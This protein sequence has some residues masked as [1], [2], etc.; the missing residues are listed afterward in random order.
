MA[1]KPLA[2]KPIIKK[3]ETATIPDKKDEIPDRPELIIDLGNALVKIILSYV[4]TKGVLRYVERSFPHA[5]AIV[6]PRQYEEGLSRAGNHGIAYN[7]VQIESNRYVI[8]ESAEQFN[9]EKRQ[10]RAKYAEDYYVPFVLSVVSQEFAECPELLRNGIDVMASHAPQDVAF[11][12]LLIKT[13][14]RSWSWSSGNATFR[15]SIRSVETF[16]E[17]FGGYNNAGMIRQE[18]VASGE[19][20]FPLIGST[21]G[22]IDI[23]G[24]TISMIKVAPDGGILKADNGIV[25]INNVLKAFEQQLLTAFPSYFGSARRIPSHAMR[26]ALATGFYKGKGDTTGFDVSAQAEVASVSLIN[27]LATL[28][29]TVLDDGLDVDMLLGSGGGSGTFQGKIR[30]ITKHEKFF[31]SEEASS[32]HYSNIR[33]AYKLSKVLKMLNKS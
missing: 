13:L 18:N 16:D 4:N 10:G 14:K 3:A 5:L 12:G 21:V 11:G 8:G 31:L 20:Q 30:S 33:G 6:N 24:G 2:E 15:M 32:I 19:W 25:G 22:V 28:Y 9:V 27:E 29:I 17:P 23:G 1:R 7:F 26:D